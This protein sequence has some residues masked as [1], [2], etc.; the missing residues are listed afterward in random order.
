MLYKVPYSENY[1]RCFYNPTKDYMLVYS[2][3][4][5]D[6][7]QVTINELNIEELK[8]YLS[9]KDRAIKEAMK[10]QP[11]EFEALLNSFLDEFEKALKEEEENEE[12]V[13]RD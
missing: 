7:Q 2:D 3:T 1:D 8:W 4:E 10:R 6:G 9:C 13:Q 12:R 5:I 11:K